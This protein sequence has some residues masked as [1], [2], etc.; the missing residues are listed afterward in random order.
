MVSR[1]GF[2]RKR[3]RIGQELSVPFLPLV[4]RECNGSTTSEWTSGSNLIFSSTVWNTGKSRKNQF[5]PHLSQRKFSYLQNGP[6][7]IRTCRVL[8]NYALLSSSSKLEMLFWLLFFRW[9][10]FLF[11]FLFQ[12]WKERIS[13]SLCASL[14]IRTFALCTRFLETHFPSRLGGWPELTWA[15]PFSLGKRDDNYDGKPHKCFFWRHQRGKEHITSPSKRA[16]DAAGPKLSPN[17]SMISRCLARKDAEKSRQPQAR[18]HW[19]IHTYTLSLGKHT[20]VSS[21]GEI[22]LVK[23]LPRAQCGVSAMT[24]L[25]ELEH[26]FFTLRSSRWSVGQV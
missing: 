21:I 8:S 2:F 10:P 3:Y 15:N 14:C 18:T 19:H 7:T 25:V 4:G 23:H 6:H 1:T 16:S 12:T 5:N 20:G 9:T 13:A 11:L 17:F 26:R 22:V 24:W